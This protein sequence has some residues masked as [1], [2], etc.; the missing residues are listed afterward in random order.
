MLR[1]QLETYIVH[2]RRHAAFS[3]CE[4]IASLSTKMVQIGNPLMMSL[5]F[6]DFNVSKLEGCNCLG[7]QE[8]NGM[9]AFFIYMVFSLNLYHVL[10]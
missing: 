6:D 7:Q 4:D 9:F 2:V 5:L 8:L 1:E 10:I 3:T